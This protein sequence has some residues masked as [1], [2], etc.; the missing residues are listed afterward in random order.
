MNGRTV[1]DDDDWRVFSEDGEPGEVDG[2][3]AG[4]IQERWSREHV[5]DLLWS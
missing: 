4:R 3:D 5:L 2:K 1:T